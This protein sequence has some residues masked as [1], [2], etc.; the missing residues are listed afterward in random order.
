MYSFPTKTVLSSHGFNCYKQFQYAICLQVSERQKNNE[1]DPEQKYFIELLKRLRYGMINDEQTYHDWK[2]LLKN[3]VTPLRL[4]EFENAT[5]LFADN[6]SCHDYNAQIIKS[7]NQ[8]IAK[9]S[10]INNPARLVKADE[11]AFSSL[12]NSIYLSIDSRITFTNNKWTDYGLVNGA[13]EI[14]RDIIYDENKTLPH[15]LFIEFDNY[16]GPYFFPENDLRHKWIPINTLTIYNSSINGSRTQMPIK[17]AYALT[18]HKSQGQTLEKVVVD[19]GKSE[20]SLGL[21]FVA[22]SRVKNHKDFLIQPFPLERLTKIK[23]SSSLEPRINEE[24]RI[25]KIVQ[26]T[27][28]E[29]SLLNQF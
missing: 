4:E 17:L 3:Q 20:K 23:K 11:D 19:L 18:I 29:F 27:L 16:S 13:N 14:V 24:T 22:L 15:T 7:L 21:A 9:F 25:E 10:A 5:R 1:N 6:A 2:F 12:Q 8:P 28:E 26:K